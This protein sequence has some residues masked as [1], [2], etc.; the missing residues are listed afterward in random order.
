ME[1]PL[2]L[3]RV[4]DFEARIDPAEFVLSQWRVPMWSL[5]RSYVAASLYDAIA[6]TKFQTK[7][8]ARTRP[9][10]DYFYHTWAGRNGATP[11]CRPLDVVYIATG[12]GNVYRQEAGN[13]F[14]WITDYCADALDARSQ[15]IELS[16]GWRYA[17]PRAHPDVSTY[18][19]WLG[20][21]AQFAA[22]ARRPSAVQARDIERYLQL[23]RGAFGD[24]LG[25]SHFL[26]MRRTL[27]VCAATAATW[28]AGYQRFFH[29]RRPKLLQID[30]AS[31]GG[32]WSYI[33]RWARAAGIPVAEFQHGYIGHDHYAYNY[34]EAVADSAYREGLPDYLL[35][36]GQYWADS[37]QTPS[38]K[39]V[40]GGPRMNEHLRA[41]TPPAGAPYVLLASTGVGADFYLSV[42]QG[43]LH[44]LPQGCTVR[45]RP[46]PGER[47]VAAANYAALLA[48]TRVCL[49]PEPDV[50]RSMEGAALVVGDITTL[51]F[52]AIGLGVP[53]RVIDCGIAR[54]RMPA[55][56]FRFL[57]YNEV[58]RLLQDRTIATRPDKRVREQVWAPHWKVRY[59]AFIAQF[60]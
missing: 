29:T 7:G 9:G 28:H 11:G 26:H 2:S 37:V 32:M 20:L 16:S 22:R 1:V 27:E 31:Y 8:G 55:S 41:A 50:Y 15:V 35:T 4:M 46:H 14:N 38:E 21:R 34:A 49:D 17:R 51:M 33:V 47:E 57:D 25:A 3:Q 48:D 42:V 23:L 44:G 24:T 43:L 54:K 13:Y 56:I 52:E 10:A 58:P 53:T 6:G 36:F 39:V 18:H 30:G 59:Q 19:D 40:I 5:V 60:L 45:F 12:N